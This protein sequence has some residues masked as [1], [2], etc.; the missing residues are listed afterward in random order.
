MT[1][2][3]VGTLAIDCVEAPHGERHE[4]IGGSASFLAA[5]AANF[6]P[7]QMVGVIGE[8]FPAGELDFFQNRGI[9][10]SGVSRADGKTFHWHGRYEKDPNIR[11]TV[12]TDLNVLT[13]FRADLPPAFRKTEYVALGNIDPEL[14]LRVLDQVENPKCVICDTM[15]YW[16]EGRNE[17]LRRMLERVQIISVNDSEA[18]QLSGEH[19]LVKAARAVR[20]MGPEYV[21]IKRGENGAI[22]FSEDDVYVV[23]ALPLES[24]IDPTG[25]GDSFAGA[26]MGY[27][28]RTGSHDVATLRKAMILGNVVASFAVEQFSLDGLRKL[29]HQQI[30][31]RYALFRKMTYFDKKLPFA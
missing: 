18:R 2:L 3:T 14:Q 21:V 27:I 11:H 9:D 1:L 24:V 8:D 4:A 6:C 25:A 29:T 13:D 12:T 28:A 30:N 19:N 7:V 23:M 5:A 15:N 26:M 10:T 20:R 22:L 31:D 16:I 17:A